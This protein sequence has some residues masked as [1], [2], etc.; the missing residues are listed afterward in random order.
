MT[1]HDRTENIEISMPLDVHNALNLFLLHQIH[2]YSP[3]M[4]EQDD[5][6]YVVHRGERI[7]I[8]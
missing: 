6:T 2:G 4:V 1:A 7:Q 5:G 3:C 8:T